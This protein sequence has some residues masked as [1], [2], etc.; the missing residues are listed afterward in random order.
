MRSGMENNATE[1]KK[2]EQ[3]IRN[4]KGQNDFPSI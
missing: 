3:Q 4:N 2:K 1:G